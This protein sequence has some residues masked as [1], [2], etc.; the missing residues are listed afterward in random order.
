MF[1]IVDGG[2]TV[3]EESGNDGRVV[4]GA[5]VAEDACAAGAWLSR[6][7]RALRRGAVGSLEAL[8]IFEDVFAVP[9]GGIT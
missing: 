4:G 2:F 6:A 9:L 5:F 1:S 7:V 3:E 8:G